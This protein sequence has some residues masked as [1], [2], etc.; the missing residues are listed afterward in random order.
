MVIDD[1]HESSTR[2]QLSIPQQGGEELLEG[3]GGVGMLESVP[4]GA[5]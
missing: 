1:R 3:D 5:V 4:N 2:N